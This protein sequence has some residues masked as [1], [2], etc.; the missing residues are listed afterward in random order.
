MKE[1]V[2]ILA[3][4]I[5][6]DPDLTES[7]LALRAD[8][9]NSTIRQMIK[10]QR[11]P[12]IDTALKICR[13]LGETVESFMSQGQDPVTKEIQLLLQQLTDEERAMLLAAAR[14]LAAQ[15]HEAGA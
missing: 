7:G 10:H 15:H 2:Q 11:S 5:E 8:L 6:A 14:G 13:A 4:R 9:D 1:F 12:R 3:E